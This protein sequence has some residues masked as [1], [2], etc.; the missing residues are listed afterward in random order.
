MPKYDAIACQLFIGGV[1]VTGW[2]EDSCWEP[3]TA[4]GHD[5]YAWDCQKDMVA[6]G[7]VWDGGK[8]FFVITE[9]ERVNERVTLI[10]GD[11]I[12]DDTIT[13]GITLGRS[14]MLTRWPEL[15][16]NHIWEN[17]NW[18]SFYKFRISGVPEE[19]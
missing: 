8:D 17:V 4:V 7:Q 16:L 2:A 10:T 9:I 14:A 15:Y 11:I 12:N 5:I 3:A 1:E 18:R 6:V 19:F 13:R